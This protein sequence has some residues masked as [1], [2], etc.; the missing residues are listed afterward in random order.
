MELPLAARGGLLVSLGNAAPIA[1]PRQLVVIHDAGVFITPGSYSRRF[2]LWYRWLHR[3]LAQGGARI[4]TVSRSARA[5]IA[6]CLGIS[7]TRIAVITEGGEH[8]LRQPADPTILA[9]HGLRPGRF[10][11]AVGN[12]AA[13]KNLAV[14]SAAAER[15]H[16][17]GQAL[18]I[19]GGL[20]PAVFSTSAA[21]PRSAVRVG[22]VDDAALRALYE[23]ASCLVMPSRYEGFGLPAVEAM[24]CGCPVVASAAG[25]LPEICGGAARMF[26]AGDPEAAYLAICAVLDERGVAAELRARG[27]VRAAAFT[28]H[29]AAEA[30]A[31]IVARQA[32]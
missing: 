21:P 24:A 25:A 6:R 29:R 11:L 26:D 17:R 7:E 22:R 8:I 18:V 14:L 23:A 31:A 13:H 2:V 15:L 9:R 27:R 3:R 32:A 20:A 30:M 5:D 28:W 16:A 1:Q 4:V 10:V 12:L 19:T